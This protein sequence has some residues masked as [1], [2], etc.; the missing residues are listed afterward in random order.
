M[1]M[2]ILHTPINV[3]SLNGCISQ[4]PVNNQVFHNV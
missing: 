1:N 4:K 3:H 2:C